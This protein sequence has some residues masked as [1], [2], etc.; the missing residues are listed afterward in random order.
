MHHHNRQVICVSPENLQV[1]IK[2][3]RNKQTGMWEVPLETQQSEAVTRNILDQKTKPELAQ[4]LNTALFSLTT[5]SLRKA[6]KQG[7]L[8]NCPGLTEKLINNHL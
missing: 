5:A 4:F 7:S 6:I 8:K 2:G 3:T 1:I